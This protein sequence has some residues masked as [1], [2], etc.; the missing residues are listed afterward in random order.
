MDGWREKKRQ[1]LIAFAAEPWSGDMG[2]GQSL[3]GAGLGRLEHKSVS[4]QDS[5]DFSNNG[6]F[7]E[8]SKKKPADRWRYRG[9]R[10]CLSKKI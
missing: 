6:H 1:Y 5:L 7:L 4:R 3:F 2:Q 8:D 10:F 9:K